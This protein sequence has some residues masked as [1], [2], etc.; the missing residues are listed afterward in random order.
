[1]SQAVYL[2]RNLP[3]NLELTR[4]LVAH[5]L[6][7]IVEP[8]ITID[9][10]PFEQPIVDKNTAIIAT[11]RYGLFGLLKTCPTINRKTRVFCVG[12]ATA[13]AAK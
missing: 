2:N 8:L 9:Y 12:G 7:V 5:K 4:R 10:L 3:D 11:S 13:E 6:P 1:M